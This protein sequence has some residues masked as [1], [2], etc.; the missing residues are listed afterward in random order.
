MAD[1][2][3]DGVKAGGTKDTRSFWER[4]FG[5]LAFLAFILYV[6]ATSTLCLILLLLGVSVSQGTLTANFLG[7]L[8]TKFA[9]TQ[10]SHRLLD[11]TGGPVA[12]LPN[13]RSWGDFWT[14]CALLGGPSFVSRRLV[15]AA[16]PSSALFGVLEG[17]VWLFDRRIKHPEGTTAWFVSFYKRCHA[18]ANDKGCTVYPE[19]TRSTKMQSMPLKPGGLAVIYKL[20]WPVQ[21]VI[22]T[23][24]EHVT[25]E[26]DL[27]LGFGVTVVTS[28]AAP[29]LPAD[30]PT[31]DEFIKAV[32][33]SWDETWADA[34][35]EKNPV[36]RQAALLPGGALRPTNFGV[37]GFPRLNAARTLFL[38]LV[39]LGWWFFAR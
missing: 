5:A 10:K 29:I 22:S 37:L 6:Q 16:F 8:G 17:R 30:F 31:S 21:V 33:A 23:N 4:S 13:H 7:I 38:A 24:K 11:D 35:G 34:Y 20:G 39:V 36:P 3:V 28:V 25:A 12:F 27:R 19:G 26:K 15:A 18:V 14:D 1:D 32:Q 9:T 2:K